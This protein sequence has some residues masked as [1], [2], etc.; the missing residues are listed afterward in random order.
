MRPPMPDIV[1]GAVL[2]YQ[3]R[4][5]KFTNKMVRVI[6]PYENPA[7]P[8]WWRVQVLTGKKL[9]PTTNTFGCDPRWLSPKGGSSAYL[10]YDRDCRQEAK[11]IKEVNDTPDGVLIDPELDVQGDVWGGLSDD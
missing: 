3:G 8:G 7:Y 4:H 5:K 11:R 9:D 10:Q 2:Q 1:A 6:E